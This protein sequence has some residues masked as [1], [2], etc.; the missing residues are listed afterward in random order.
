MRRLVRRVLAAAAPLGELQ[1]VERLAR[2]ALDTGS[3]ALVVLGSLMPRSGTT[4]HYRQL[5]K[6]LA[7]ANLPTFYVPGPDDAPVQEYLQEACNIE[8]VYPFLH[9]VHGT[10]AFG[11]G[12]VL[13]AGMGGEILDDPETR[14]EES[15]RLR[16]PAW[17]VEY[18]FKVLQELK[19]YQKVFLFTA[20]P[21]HKGLH[22]RGSAV[23]AEVIKSYKPRLVLVPGPRK[24]E[25]LGSS[26]LVMPGRLSEGDFVVVDLRE[27]KIEVGDVR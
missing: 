23:L 5:F 13:F 20:A 9:G 14:R 1:M 3:E 7:E 11:P 6:T 16:Y 18:R 25:R 4:G 24:H 8:I 10:F 2:L 12:H 26:L 17:E 22:E 21:E 15:E 27:E 19:D